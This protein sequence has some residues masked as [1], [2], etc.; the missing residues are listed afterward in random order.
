MI[1]NVC[2]AAVAAI[3]LA[4]PPSA[5]AYWPYGGG[6]PWNYGYAYNYGV[7]YVPPPPYF[8]V[9]PPVYYSP[10]ITA[11]PYGASPFAWPAGYSPDDA[12]AALRG[13]CG[14][15]RSA[16]DHQ[17]LREAVAASEK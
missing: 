5:Q 7:G 16:G 15:P 12:R 8:S 10:Q 1:R 13:R 4:V 14:S 6:G 3:L 9:F 11:R 2:L 17:S